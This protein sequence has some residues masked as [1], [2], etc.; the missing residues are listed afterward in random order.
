MLFSGFGLILVIL[1]DLFDML[2]ELENIKVKWGLFKIE[3]SN[4]IWVGANQLFDCFSP[5][6]RKFCFI[7]SFPISSLSLLF[8][9]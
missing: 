4:Y 5:F 6:F 7:L 3:Y 1:F 2:A 9:D 8:F